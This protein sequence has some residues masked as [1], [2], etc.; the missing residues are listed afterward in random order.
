[1]VALVA[2]RS[3]NARPF[4]T[5]LW[6]VADGGTL[7][8]TTGSQ[9]WTGRIVSRHP[10]IVMLFT[11]ERS[12]RTD[13]VLRLRDGDRLAWSAA[14]AGTAPHRREVLRFPSGV[15]CGVAQPL[16][17]GPPDA[18]LQAN[19]GRTRTHSSRSR[20]GRVSVATRRSPMN[21]FPRNDRPLHLS[22][23]EG[24]CDD[25]RRAAVTA[26]MTQARGGAWPHPE[27]RVGRS[28]ST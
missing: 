21:D 13:R 7:F 11:A 3:P 28:T 1:M 9:S 23:P 17:V 5:P 25:E 16:E 18:L 14:V 20:D 10:D 27:L 26:A 15:T 4:M 19:E 8:I 22:G 6:F 12:G 24:Q 2:T